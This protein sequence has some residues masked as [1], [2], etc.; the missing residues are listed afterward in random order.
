M[1]IT[2]T[3]HSFSVSNRPVSVWLYVILLICSS[4][5]SN[6]HPAPESILFAGGSGTAQDPFLIST[7]NHLQAIRNSSHSAHFR[8]IN[9]IDAG[10]TATWNGGQ[11]FNPIGWFNG[12]IDGAG[13]TINGLVINRP[14]TSQAAFINQLGGAGIVKNIQFNTITIAGGTLTASVVGALSGTI[15]NV[16]VSGT[17][18][19]SGTVGGLVGQVYSDGN[20]QDCHADMDITATALNVGG[21]AGYNTGGNIENSTSAG[22]V[23]GNSR[24]GGLVGLNEGNITNC[25]STAASSG[26]GDDIGGLIG[27]NNSGTLTDISAEGSVSGN[28]NVGGLIGFNG[29][30]TSSVKNAHSTSSVNGNAR[31]GGLIGFNQDGTVENTYSTGTVQGVSEVGGLMGFMAYGSAI[32][33]TSF[34]TSNVTGSAN[35]VGG[36]IGSLQSGQVQNCYATGDVS[37]NNRVG[38]LVG[39]ALWSASVTSSFSNG[40]V[41]GQGGQT[42]GLI[43]RNQQSS[44]T[45]SFWDI[46]TSGQNSSSGGTPR[47]TAEMLDESTF[48]GW[49]FDD[50]WSI[51]PEINNGY[52]YLT[53]LGGFFMM[54]WTGDIDTAWENP[55]NWSSGNIPVP[56]DDVEIPDVTNQPVISST[57][58]INNMTIQ[59]NSNVTIAPNGAF[60]L[61]GSIN[62]MAG[63]SGLV[64]NSDENGTG[65]LIHNNNG[66]QA[67]FQRFVHG[68]AQAW[69]MLSSPMTNQ[70]ISGDFTP[71]GSYGDGTGYDFYTWYEPDTSW[72]YLLN[73]DFAPNW[74]TAN[75]SNNFVPGKGYLV[76]YQQ[77]NPTLAFSGTLSNDNVSIGLT[78]SPGDTTLYGANLVGNPYCSSIDWKATSGWDRSQLESSGGGYD[79]WIWND[80]ANNYGV[81]N[82]ASAVDIGTLGV[83]RYIAPTQGFF[84]SASQTGNLV[85]NNAIRVHDGAD[86]WLKTTSQ[87][88]KKL[89]LKVISES[90]FGTDEVLLEFSDRH[91][92]GG[93]RKKFSFVNTA[94]SLY[95]PQNEI[96]YSTRLFTEV[97]SNPVLPLCFKAGKADTFTITAS[98]KHY[99]FETLI[100][101]DKL[102]GKQQN[103]I[104]DPVFV[105]NSG[106]KDSP[107]RFIL[108]L[109]EGHYAN[110]FDEVPVKIYSNKG[111]LYLDMRLLEQGSKFEL[112]VMDVMGRGVYRQTVNGGSAESIPFPH[113]KGL[114]IIRFAGRQGMISEKVFF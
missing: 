30:G 83:T 63:P 107:Q 105:F 53:A 66:V 81:Y 55:G 41:T 96:N 58:V 19:G 42:G 37:G 113:L 80:V 78:R 112:E 71:S 4:L 47:T 1:N 93:T 104:D 28:N 98:F 75:G 34:S 45:D 3:A 59:P 9:N 13:F 77:T 95:L 5:F 16:S 111:T 94:P 7:V 100:L 57:V 21:L 101:E 72:V 91:S 65:S 56:N 12:T 103:L 32:V 36:L 39:E 102:T 11:G 23:S 109:K 54:V 10:A 70:A 85:M 38:G 25:H 68:E 108:H 43:G 33:K 50:I 67:T 73:T 74:L 17:L 49:D 114:F 110:P 24:V 52:P 51:D 62:N 14:G 84:V 35:Q 27:R 76:S 15:E 18:S 20:I 2:K 31:V 26:N 22:T 44:A 106:P 87:F 61:T 90:G 89:S 40:Y 64:I 46:E 97:E 82:S 48:A 6:A 29:Y 92:K 69:H 99:M 86:N 8:L 88:T 60:T 79:I